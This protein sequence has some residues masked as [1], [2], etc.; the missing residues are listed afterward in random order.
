MRTFLPHLGATASGALGAMSRGWWRMTVLLIIVAALGAVLLVTAAPLLRVS[1]AFVPQA[2]D[3]AGTTIA[4]TWYVVLGSVINWLVTAPALVLGPAATVI[5]AADVLAGRRLSL[6]GE[7]GQLVSRAPAALGAFLIAFFALIGSVLVTTPLIYFAFFST[8][9][10][11]VLLVLYARTERLHRRAVFWT[12]LVLLPFALPTYI[13]VRWAFALV[14]AVADGAGPLEALVRS[15][16]LTSGRW[17]EVFVMVGLG[18]LA[19]AIIDVVIVSGAL[20]LAGITTDSPGLSGALAQAFYLFGGALVA[21]IPFAVLTAY[22]FQIG[23]ARPRAERRR[24]ARA[25]TRRG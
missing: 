24:V 3:D 15:W 8:L 12:G 13:T 7:I 23:E 20:G 25:R 4:A 16:T 19:A 17:L 21:G 2:K 22:Y 9:P 18:A 6:R 10:G 11:I 14:A 5:V 1:T